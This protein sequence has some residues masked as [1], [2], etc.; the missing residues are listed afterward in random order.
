MN[1]RYVLRRLLQVLPAV[2]SILIV[3]FAVVQAAPGDPVVAVAGESGNEE[4]Y[5]FMREKFGL[6][7]PVVEQFW[8]YATNVLRGDMGV[9]FVQGQEVVSLILERVPATLLL[10]GSALLVSTVGGV[11]LGALAA[12]RPFGPF[13][14]GLSTGALIGYALPSFWLAQLAMLT[15]AF[16]TGWFPIQGMTDARA[17][18][19]GLAHYLDIARHLVLPSLV[20]AASEVALITRIARTGILAEMD[21]DY[22]RVAQA[23]GLSS[24]GALVHHALRNALLPVVTVVGTRIGFLFSGAVLVETVFGWPGLGRLVLSAAQTRDH[25]LLL[26]MVLVVAFSLVLSNLLTDLLYARVDPRIRY[27]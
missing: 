26:G 7:R 27:R 4:Y 18:Y 8:T 20:L 23:K 11:A 2:A 17:D 22:V 25:P 24:T 14:L 6:D 13:D 16:R 9:S 15:I 19:S 21:S 3:T 5:A 12:R 10:M 1:R